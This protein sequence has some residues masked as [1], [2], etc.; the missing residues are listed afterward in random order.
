MHVL[1]GNPK[2][3]MNHLKNTMRTIHD[4]DI[5]SNMEHLMNTIMIIWNTPHKQS[6]YI[7]DEIGQVNITKSWIQEKYTMKYKKCRI[8]EK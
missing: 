3:I 5:R 8:K 6:C 2:Y 7:I 4:I 1:G